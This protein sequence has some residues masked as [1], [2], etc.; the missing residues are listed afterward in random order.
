MEDKGL[1]PMQKT[2]RRKGH[3]MRAGRVRFFFWKIEKFL[4]KW[5]Q[6]GKFLKVRKGKS[7]L[8]SR[9]NQLSHYLVIF[10][11]GIRTHTRRRGFGLWS[12]FVWTPA[13]D[14]SLK[15]N[16]TPQKPSEL[17]QF[18]E[19]Q[20]KPRAFRKPEKICFLTIYELILRKGIF[21]RGGRCAIFGK[22]FCKN[23]PKIAPPSPGM[24]IPFLKAN[25]YMVRKHIFSSFRKGLAFLNFHRITE[26][27]SVLWLS[28]YD[29]SWTSVVE[30]TLQKWP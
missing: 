29:R 2:V 4:Y 6:L 22:Y 9:S 12:R 15:L 11:K 1:L 24:R 5:L 17:P 14:L 7:F 18:F 30:T 10:E 26:L 25:S 20:K 23:W 16:T 13:K 19:I 28:F 21:M 27:W 8:K 3:S